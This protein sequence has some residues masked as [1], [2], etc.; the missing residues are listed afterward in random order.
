MQSYWLEF[1]A[2]LEKRKK[3]LTKDA[4]TFEGADGRLKAL[5]IWP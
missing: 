5:V 2:L 4:K 1:D 3:G